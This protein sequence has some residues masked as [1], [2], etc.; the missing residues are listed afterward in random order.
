MKI[1]DMLAKRFM[2]AGGCHIMLWNEVHP[3]LFSSAGLLK[4]G[5]Q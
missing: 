3:F 1:Q 2:P 5:L 4:V